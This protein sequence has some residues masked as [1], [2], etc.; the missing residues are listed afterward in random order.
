M[1]LLE[2][3]GMGWRTV[4]FRT[5]DPPR[6]EVLSWVRE[7]AAYTKWCGAHPEVERGAENGEVLFDITIHGNSG[8]LTASTDDFADI[9]AR[10]AIDIAP[11]DSELMLIAVDAG[12]QLRDQKIVNEPG[13]I[14]FLP[15]RASRE[16]FERLS[17]EASMDAL[18][19]ELAVH[20]R[21]LLKDL[22]DFNDATGPRAWAK[23]FRVQF[24]AR[25]DALAVINCARRMER[26]ARDLQRRLNGNMHINAALQTFRQRTSHVTDLRNISEHLDE[27]VVGAGQ[28]DG[29]EHREPGEVFEIRMDREDVVLSARS[30]S[31]RILSVASAVKDLCQCVQRT[32]EARFMELT[33]ADGVKFD[34]AIIEQDGTSRTLREDEYSL[35]LLEAIEAMAQASENGN[36][37]FQQISEECPSCGSGL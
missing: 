29:A 11:H 24:I 9:A 30:R 31:A 36:P 34:H 2:G 8:F 37:F 22:K 25:V 13:Q 18:L 33:W 26:I 4:Q 3:V 17:G 1:L 14:V 10:I 27:H 23:R 6:R 20:E 28:I 21:R 12:N 15:T 35:I 5:T 16:G 32:T 7:F 19:Q